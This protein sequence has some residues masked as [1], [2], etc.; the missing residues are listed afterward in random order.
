MDGAALDSAR[1]GSLPG[2]DD[3]TDHPLDTPVSDDATC[4][5]SL[6]LV[7]AEDF[8]LNGSISDKDGDKDAPYMD[9][10]AVYSARYGSSL[11]QYDDKD[12]ALDV[13]C[14][15]IWHMDGGDAAPDEQIH[16]SPSSNSHTPKKEFALEQISTPL[17]C[18]QCDMHTPDKQPQKRVAPNGEIRAT[19]DVASS[20]VPPVCTGSALVPSVP[21]GAPR[22]ASS[23]ELRHIFTFTPLLAGIYA[24]RHWPSDPIYPCGKKAY[25][26][27]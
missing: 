21:H 10:A 3:D 22:A 6:A 25:C 4:F 1:N 20:V 26:R 23:T 19:P 14:E 13:L 24:E 12:H 16:L 7:A 9:G 17:P 27:E 5:A 8:A 11:G 2:K 15:P 18:K